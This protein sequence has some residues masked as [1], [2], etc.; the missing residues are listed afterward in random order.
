MRTEPPTRVLIVVFDG[1][2][3]DMVT[4]ETMPTLRRFADE[5][6]WYPN[7]RAVFPS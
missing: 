2:R 5:G 1:L 3:P 4:E 7:A 6:V